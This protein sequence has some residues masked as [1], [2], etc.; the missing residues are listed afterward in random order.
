MGEFLV[1]IEVTLPHDMTAPMRTRL[2]DAEAARG[3]ELLAAGRLHR[4]WRL[5]GRLANISIYN[6]TDASELHELLSSLPL[7]PWMSVQVTA[8]AEHPITDSSSVSL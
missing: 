1:E 3:R 5:P 4:I 2:L 7:F 8:L 6:V